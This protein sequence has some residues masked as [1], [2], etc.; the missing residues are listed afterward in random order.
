MYSFFYEENV[1][2]VEKITKAELLS[3]INDV[4]LGGVYNKMIPVT[5]KE[6]KI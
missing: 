5:Q 2:L 3:A 6:Q 1:V 4:F